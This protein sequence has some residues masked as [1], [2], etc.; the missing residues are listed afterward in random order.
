MNKVD[1]KILSAHSISRTVYA[2]IN[3]VSFGRASLCEVYIGY[4]MTDSIVS[5]RL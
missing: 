4:M 3:T 2:Y 1:Y 5:T